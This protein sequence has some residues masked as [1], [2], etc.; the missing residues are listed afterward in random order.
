MAISE[1]HAERRAWDRSQGI[2]LRR[3]HGQLVHTRIER[4][5]SPPAGFDVAAA[6]E[7]HLDQ[8]PT[9]EGLLVLLDAWMYQSQVSGLGEHV[10]GYAA[11]IEHAKSV[12]REAPDAAIAI[13]V[14]QRSDA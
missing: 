8:F 12:L 14:L 4:R 3:R 6:L 9:R 13:A 10:E 1:T 5:H 2:P 7:L 11:A